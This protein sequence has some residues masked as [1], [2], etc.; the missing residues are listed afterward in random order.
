MEIKPNTDVYKDPTT[1]KKW[2][3]VSMSNDA[4]RFIKFAVES[5]KGDKDDKK[6][7]AIRDDVHQLWRVMNPS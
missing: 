7:E 4:I 2:I 5:Y 6:M 3:N 1:G